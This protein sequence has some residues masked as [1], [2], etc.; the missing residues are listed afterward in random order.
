[1]EKLTHRMK[2]IGVDRKSAS[3]SDEYDRITAIFGDFAESTVEVFAISFL[4]IGAM[5]LE[6][7]QELHTLNKDL[8]NKDSERMHITVH[9]IFRRLSLKQ[10]CGA[11]STLNWTGDFIFPGF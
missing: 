11:W 2:V 6:Y 7:I 1:M 10:P 3:W 8:K 5:S 4:G 9:R